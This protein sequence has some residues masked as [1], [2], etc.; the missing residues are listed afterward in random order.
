MKEA[1]PRYRE[2]GAEVLAISAD[3]I[4]SHEKFAEKL[5]GVPFPMLSD[6]ELSAIQAYGVPN[7]KGTGA[8]RSAFVV[9]K[10]GRIAYANI[11]FGASNEKHY[12]ELLNAL[13]KLS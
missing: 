11:K 2:H 4:A 6:R 7:E 8:R 1:Y 10:T 13:S 3:T 12:Q 9:D 5:G